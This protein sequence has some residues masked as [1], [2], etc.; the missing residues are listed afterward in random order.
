MVLMRGKGNGG[1]YF[2]FF[3]RGRQKHVCDLPYLS[4]TK[5]ETVV[6][7]HFATVRLS[8]SFC[9]SVRRQLD[10]AL[11]LEHRTMS[12]L[13][14][15]LGARLDELDTREDGLLDLVGDPAWP[16][17]KIK[18]KLTGI[19]RERGEIQAQ[20]ADVGS[21]LETGRQFFAAALDL[22]ADPQGFYQRG[23]A[24]VKRAMTKV[25]FSKLHVDAEQITG[26]ELTEG[27]RELIEAGTPGHTA[28]RHHLATDSNDEGGPFP[29]EGAAF[30]HVTDTD[31]LDVVLL[32]HGSS[33]AAMVELGGIEPLTFSMRMRI[34]PFA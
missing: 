22:L 27:F 32:D 29:E 33:R 28:R 23:S 9:A 18:G 21:K 31:L 20:L 10:D 13:K 24:A 19:E 4:V 14:K 2:Y 1:T 11:L 30:D 17:A 34:D 26:H 5:I 16:R 8:D 25:I 12:G 15:R 7:R 3:C 6:E